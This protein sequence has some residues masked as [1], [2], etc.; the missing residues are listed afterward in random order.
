MGRPGDG[1]NCKPGVLFGSSMVS[2]V[3]SGF[4]KP[5]DRVRLAEGLT[6]IFRALFL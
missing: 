3:S 2:P 4:G 6:L 1:R 5:H